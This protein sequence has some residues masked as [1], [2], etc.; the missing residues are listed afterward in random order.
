MNTETTEANPNGERNPRCPRITL[1]DAIDRLGQLQKA[2]GKSAVDAAAASKAIGYSGPSGAALT[3]IGSMSMYG[4]VT[5]NQGKVAIAELGRRVLFPMPND[6]NGEAAKKEAALSPKMFKRINT[7]F[8]DL[9]IDVLGSQLVHL[10]FDEA[11]AKHTAKIYKA[12]KEYAKLQNGEKG[13]LDTG[14]E[15]EDNADLGAGKSRPPPPLSTMSS[16]VQ[17]LP[18]PLGNGLVAYVPYPMTGAAFEMLKEALDLYKNMIVTPA[19]GEHPTPPRPK[20]PDPS[21]H[22]MAGQH[23]RGT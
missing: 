12:N 18:V 1:Q 14:S 19:A 5:R 20:A 6:K 22:P 2:I 7:E 16:S 9:D 21:A 8:D 15:N 10:G 23:P 13:P 11:T 17:S 3:T 4:L